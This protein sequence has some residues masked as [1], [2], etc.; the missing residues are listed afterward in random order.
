[1]V[2]NFLNQNNAADQRVFQLLSEKFSLFEGVFGASDEVLGALESGVDF[3]KRIADIYQRC[4]TPEEINASFDQL[5]RELSQQIDAA[6]TR[7]RQ[8]LLENFDEEVLEKLRV[9][10]ESSRTYLDRY[11]RM[12]MEL[13]RYELGDSAEFLDGQSAFRLQS[14]PFPGDIPLGLY[15]LPRRSGEAHLYRLAH[16]LAQHVLT[17]ARGRALPPAEIV[18]DY[19][20]YRPT[21]SILEPLVGQ[22]GALLLSLLTVQS[23]DQVE[24]YLIVAAM[25]DG[26]HA[27][28]EEQARRLLRLPARDCRIL[29]TLPASEPVTSLT[30]LHQ[31]AILKTI[32][33]RNAA[34][35]EA[36]ANKLDGWADDLKAG[37]EREIK[38][39]DRQ[40]KEARRAATAALTLEEKLEA[41]KRIKAIEAQR[42]TRRRALFDAQDDIDR[43][44]EQ[45]IAEIEGKLEQ[46][47]TLLELFSIRWTIV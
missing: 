16:P 40:I 46:K 31:E 1:V 24:D 37:L 39:L 29:A 36:E 9:N 47:T 12:L 43:R 25:T 15:E 7:A 4:R 14:C 42:N 30:A 20:H 45:L 33:Q 18:F 35:F 26:G 34:F 2:V 10:L 3:E 19:T 22:S 21:V 44:R 23:L 41:Q 38:E 8:Q 6:M 32:S 13:T 28:D 27:L 11:E 5:Q 17:Q